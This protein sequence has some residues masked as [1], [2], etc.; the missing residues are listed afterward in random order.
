MGG[1]FTFEYE[2]NSFHLRVCQL[3]FLNLFDPFDEE[4][5]LRD[6]LAFVI[7]LDLLSDFLLR[8]VDAMY[9]GSETLLLLEQYH[10]SLLV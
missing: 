9:L 2:V 3:L 1:Y 4:F 5:T 6:Q 8:S 7:T 10:Q